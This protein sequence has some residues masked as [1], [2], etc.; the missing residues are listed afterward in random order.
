MAY[1]KFNFPTKKALKEHVKAR[2][3][4]SLAGDGLWVM[5]GHMLEELTEMQP[6]DR[7]SIEGPHAPAPHRW[8]ATLSRRD[9]GV[10]VVK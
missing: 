9:D 6:G 10:L 7:F 8:Y 5:H 3:G 1:T 4:G 2:N